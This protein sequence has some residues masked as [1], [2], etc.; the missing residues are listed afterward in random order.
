MQLGKVSVLITA[1]NASRFI[2][3]SIESVL[4]QSYP[5]IEVIVCDD[6]STDNTLDVIRQFQDE[7]IYVI[8][9]PQNQGVSISRNNCIVRATGDFIAILDADDVWHINKIE[10]QVRF[11]AANPDVG[12]VGTN[13]NEIDDSGLKIGRRCYPQKHRAILDHRL[14]ACP[15]LHSSI[16]VRREAMCQYSPGTKQAEDWELESKILSEWKGA[17]LQEDLVS[18]RV[19]ASNLTNSRAVEQRCAA[20]EVVRDFPEIR[21]LSAYEFDLYSKIFNYE[22]DRV[23]CAIAG[24]IVVAK[25][26][27]YSNFERASRIRVA[28]LMG[29]AKNRIFRY[30]GL[31]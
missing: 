31:Q 19:H 27:R 11:L 25:L 4:R 17:N 18:Y 9:N 26:G 7:R 13:A 24:L 20:L 12:I 5:N 29:L 30:I 1:Y 2:R 28:W 16:I 22:L 21:N 3:H 10:R 15:F 23:D 6:C 14:W 8:Q